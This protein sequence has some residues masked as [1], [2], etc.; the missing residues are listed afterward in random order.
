MKGKAYITGAD[1]GLGLG[2]V[3]TLLE[4]KYKV[5]AGS[6]MPEWHELKEVADQYKEDLVIIPLDVSNDESVNKAAEKI[7]QDTKYLN[8]II[9]NAGSARDRSGTIFEKQY[10]E[11]IRSLLEINALGPL[12]VT[13]SALELLLNG[14]ELKILV[15]ISSIAGSPALLT[16]VS[17]FG[18]TMSKAAVNTQ[19]KLL[20]NN[21]KDQGVKVFAIHPGW[22]R[23]HLFGD[24]N[25]M[26][27]APLEPIDSARAII[28]LI[29]TRMEINDDIFM[30]YQG[31]SLPW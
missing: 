28:N 15:N 1:R 29:H 14:G 27:D 5:Y 10:Y 16:R 22:M 20:H 2:L 4:Q 23:S 17:Q 30:D 6:Y 12:R 21:L 18:Y 9:N 7:K 25:R 24:I 19:S 3:T 26:K 31:E 11:D 13:Q 8:I